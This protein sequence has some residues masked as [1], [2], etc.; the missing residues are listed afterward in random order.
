M[1]I[2]EIYRNL[3]HCMLRKIHMIQI[4]TTI[5]S[6]GGD[7]ILTDTELYMDTIRFIMIYFGAKRCKQYKYTKNIHKLLYFWGD[8]QKSLV[9]FWKEKGII[10]DETIIKL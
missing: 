3:E 4:I 1:S 6:N 10:C 9:P 8:E 7:Y 2:S 5:K